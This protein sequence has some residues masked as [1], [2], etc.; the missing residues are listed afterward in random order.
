VRIHQ[1]PEE[2]EPPIRTLTKFTNLPIHKFT[3]SS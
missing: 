1:E 2:K 3:K